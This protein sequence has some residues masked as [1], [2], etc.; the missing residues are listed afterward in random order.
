MQKSNSVDADSLFED[1]HFLHV[2]ELKSL[3]ERFGL[4]ALGKK[5]QL[6]KVIM[7]YVTTG[8]I[9]EEKPLP[10]QS[11]VLA[12]APELKPKSFI[13]FGAYKNDLKTRLFMKQLVGEHFHFTAYGIAW[14]NDCWKQGKPPTYAEFATF[15][16]EEYSRRLKTPA[17][18]KKEWAYITFLQIY[19]AHNPKASKAEMLAAWKHERQKAVERVWLNLGKE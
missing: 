14:I 12:T 17:Q 4:P 5:E 7:G 18:P 15:W 13:L 2:K 10:A 1:L 6:I 9:T 11:C 8:E 19:R 16:Q 3:C